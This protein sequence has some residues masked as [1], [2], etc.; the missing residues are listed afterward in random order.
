VSP[1]VSFA[2]PRVAS[3]ADET[4]AYIDRHPSI[5]G[6]LQA[7]L[8]NFAF[9]A[10]KIQS[11]RGLRN[12]EAIE[13]ALRRYQQEMRAASPAANAIREVVARSHLDV[14][15]PI[16]ILRIREDQEVLDRLYEIGKGL[17]PELRHQGIFQFFQGTSA[18]T[19]LCGES[20]LPVILGSIPKRNLLTVERGLGSV[21]L[22][23]GG[24]AGDVPGVLSAVA[25]E[26]YERGINCL[27]SVSVNSNA[28]L[29]F[30]GGDVVRG[31]SVLSGMIARPPNGMPRTGRAASPAREARRA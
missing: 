19:V 23:T 2:K 27:E 11:E 13:I 28:I 20:L 14:Q 17:L 21:V 12:E 29:V 24:P 31:V 30:R 6:A 16:A 3:A 5:R 15:S 7:D 18:L 10:R 4:R 1:S 26:L 22:R 8:V 9:L 25:E